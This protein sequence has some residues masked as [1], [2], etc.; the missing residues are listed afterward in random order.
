MEHSDIFQTLQEENR[1]RHKRLDLEQIKPFDCG[2][3]DLN[4][5]LF[6]EAAIHQ[7]HFG[8]VTYLLETDSETIAYYSLSND[9]LKIDD[10]ENF[11]E[12]LS[13]I[14]IHTN[15]FEFFFE[16]DTYPAVKIGRLAVTKNYQSKG[17]GQFIIDYLI[18]SFRTNNKA[19]CQ[20]ITVDAINQ[21][22][23]LSFYDRNKFIPLT[24]AD[25][26]KHSRQMYLPLL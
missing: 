25:C 17:I 3:N 18:E 14:D 5:F 26:N 4:D 20:F 21:P 23:V 22:R 2:E 16:Q 6:N 15:Y 19:G 9:S 1:L 10:K 11:K 12:E 13:E 8:L 7:K 24:V